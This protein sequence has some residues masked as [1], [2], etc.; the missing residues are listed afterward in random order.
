MGLVSAMVMGSCEC[1]SSR[2]IAL[3]MAFLITLE[4]DRLPIPLKAGSSR[5]YILDVVQKNVLPPSDVIGLDLDLLD[6][7]T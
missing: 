3:P 7:S 6:P 1:F 2:T 5:E 4:L